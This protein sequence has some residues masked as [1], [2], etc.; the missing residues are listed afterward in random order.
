MDTWFSIFSVSEK[1]I[2]QKTRFWVNEFDLSLKQ[3]G[4]PEKSNLMKM[5]YEQM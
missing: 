3:M 5:V 2:N 4:L 1:G